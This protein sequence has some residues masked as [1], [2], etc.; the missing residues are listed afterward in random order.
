MPT[1]NHGY[2]RLIEMLIL[3]VGTAIWYRVTKWRMRRRLESR[4]SRPV[5]EDELLSI[6]SWSEE[7]A[8]AG[9]DEA[10]AG[11]E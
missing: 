6:N 1:L 8:D 4:L 7:R 5:T 3:A 10:R 9:R 11:R 2:Y